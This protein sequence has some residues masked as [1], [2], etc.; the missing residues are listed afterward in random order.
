MKV[1][2]ITEPHQIRRI[3]ISDAVTPV[4]SAKVKLLKAGIS[5]SDAEI[6]SGD[7]RVRY[8]IVPGHQAVG[9]ISEV[10]E[11]NRGL[12]KGQRVFVNPYVPCNSCIGCISGNYEMCANL[13]TM[14]LDTEGLLRDFA[15]IPVENLYQLPSNVKDNDALFIEH[16]AI[17]VRV[18]SELDV[19]K[20][21]HLAIH[22]SSIVGLI[23][24]QVALYY[25]AIPIL[26]DN[27]AYHLECAREM[28]VYYTIDS[29]VE[30][31]AQ[32]L[33]QLTGGRGCEKVAHMASSSRA[34]RSALDFCGNGAKLA[35]VGHNLR[36][37]LKESA[38]SDIIDKQLT[39]IGINNSYDYIEN[40]INLIANKAV[41][42]G[43]LVDKEI[44]FDEVPALLREL[45][46]SHYH[47]NKVIVKL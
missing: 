45:E 42:P 40:G 19:Q 46:E 23:L 2:E 27:N 47:N 33:M 16:T 17:A 43:A 24:A 10:G 34:L 14:G 1:W 30:D 3:E 9:V 31:A 36:S 37:I 18:F 25:Q 39:L 7:T 35:V 13:K 8:P 21:E 15:V 5:Y 6:Y 29:S 28:N 26:I 4:G 38:Y 41:Q 44:S 12:A 32:K 11:N 20:G 22:G